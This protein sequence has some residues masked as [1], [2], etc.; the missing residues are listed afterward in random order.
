MNMKTRWAQVIVI[1]GAMNFF[2][3]ARAQCPLDASPGTVTDHDIEGQ[4]ESLKLVPT[5]SNSIAIALKL[6]NTTKYTA[7][8]ITV[9]NFKLSS[10][11]GAQLGK[12]DDVAL[13]ICQESTSDKENPG[14]CLQRQSDNLSQ[15]NEIAPCGAIRGTLY[16][17][18]TNGMD[19]KSGDALLNYVYKGI[20]RFSE[21]SGGPMA[22]DKPAG[23]PHIATMAFQPLPI[24]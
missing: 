23:P 1:G 4:V 18:S 22:A 8:I 9:G 3:P 17:G 13:N 19:L 7:H 14:E 2:N 6:R 5:R 20:V 12:Y 10:G 21:N 15:F 11:S 16:F 24:P